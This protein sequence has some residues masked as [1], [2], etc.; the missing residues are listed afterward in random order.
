MQPARIEISK[1]K[2]IPNPHIYI[3][4]LQ[5]YPEWAFDEE[6]A[7]TFKGKWKSD[8]FKIAPDAPLDLEI[9]TGNGFFF[10]HRALQEPNRSLV[11]LEIKY[12]PLIQAIRRALD[13]KSTNMRIARYDASFI[14]DLFAEGEINDVFIHHPDP[15]N[16]VRRHKHRLLQ[17]EFL[18]KLAKIQKPG[19]FLE[20][21]TD[22]RDYFLWAEDQIAK[23]PYKAVKRTLDLHKSEYA[24][25]NFKTHFEKLFSEKRVEINYTL[26]QL[27]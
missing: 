12:K 9:G 2:N 3:K 25:E 13:Q 5:D 10:A 17:P 27:P 7:P 22:S 24:P 19:S 23:S 20:F 4:A 11:G 8:I 6:Q 15:W 14:E 16:K 26:L 21:K 18:N 1:T